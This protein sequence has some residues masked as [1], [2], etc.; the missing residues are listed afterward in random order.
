MAVRPVNWVI[1]SSKKG[2][3]D[4]LGY[5]CMEKTGLAHSIDILRGKCALNGAI[6]HLAVYVWS[7]MHHAKQS[8]LS[9]VSIVN[10]LNC[11]TYRSSAAEEQIWRVG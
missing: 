10:C 7:R 1:I 8:Q 4:V 6:P 9:P 2:I 3:Q 5:N 11:Q